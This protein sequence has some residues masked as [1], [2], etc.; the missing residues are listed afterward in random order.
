MSAA[1]APPPP[2][3]KPNPRQHSPS[4]LFSIR[5]RNKPGLLLAHLDHAHGDGP[6]PAAAA[7]AFASSAGIAHASRA[8][9]RTVA[10]HYFCHWNDRLSVCRDRFAVDRLHTRLPKNTFLQGLQKSHTAHG[11]TSLHGN[12]I[13]LGASTLRSGFV[14]FSGSLLASESQRL[15]AKRSSSFR[16]L[17]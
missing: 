17:Q 10:I 9:T 5:N 16:E 6:H 3:T 8:R 7:T 12:I 1:F 4:Q 13:P 14:V 2:H 11:R 15:R